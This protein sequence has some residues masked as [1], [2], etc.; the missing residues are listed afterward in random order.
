MWGTIRL[1][2]TLTGRFGGRPSRLHQTDC[3]RWH[4]AAATLRHLLK[5]TRLQNSADTRWHL[6]TTEHLSNVLLLRCAQRRGLEDVAQAIVYLNTTGVWPRSDALNALLTCYSRHHLFDR[7]CQLLRE[8]EILGLLPNDQTVANIIHGAG[9]APVPTSEYFVAF[10]EQLYRVGQ[11]S[12]RLSMCRTVDEVYLQIKGHRVQLK[13][14]AAAARWAPHPSDPSVP[15]SHS[16]A[17]AGAQAVEPIPGA[18]P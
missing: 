14:D 2:S 8:M 1:C 13:P 3:R 7:A 16:P 11:R 15:A 9:K 6:W 5:V 17:P 4:S 18:G 12:N 10:L